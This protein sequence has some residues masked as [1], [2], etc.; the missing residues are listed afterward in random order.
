[1]KFN[2]YF[3]IGFYLF[4]RLFRVLTHTHTHKKVETMIRRKIAKK[5]RR[6]IERY[7]VDEFAQ[8]NYKNSHMNQENVLNILNNSYN[9]VED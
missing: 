4:P 9:S 1:M 3:P 8:E 6:K 7:R 2:S 5:E